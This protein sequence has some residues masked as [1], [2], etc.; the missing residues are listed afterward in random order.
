M[1]FAKMLMAFTARLS[2]AGLLIANMLVTGAQ[3][4]DRIVI[5]QYGTVLATLP[6]AVALNRGFLNKHALDIDGFIGSNGGGTSIRNMI[7]SHIPFAE[8]AP[9]AAIAGVRSGLK[10]KI[11]FTATN[12]T[13]DLNWMVLKD[14]PIK[15][16]A[17]LK[18]R[19]IGFD[20]PQGA[21]EMEIRLVLQR[22]KM[23]GAAELIT[24]G[25]SAVGVTALESGAID[26]APYPNAN[27]PP[28][29]RILF[30]VIQYIPQLT[31]EVGV[32]TEDYAKERP[33][34]LRALVAARREAVD[35][36]YSHPA[37]A[38]QIYANVW[39]VDESVAR[40]IVNS[41]IQ[42]NYW[43]RGNF[44]QDGLT[45]MAQGMNLVN[46]ANATVDINT[47]IDRRFLPA[48]L[49]K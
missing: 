42:K 37:E 1:V 7:A 33:D 29:E 20:S 35:Y 38:A 18:G 24:T 9:A 3:A 28:K 8:V 6:W 30:K 36:I 25:G 16:L 13:A 23:D 40:P 15:T 19:K 46:P 41:A 10:L 47:L 44:I 22:N 43:S 32:T 39:A 21:T 11:I 26:A 4:S 12:N 34:T 5:T 14:S 49:R 45:S 17:D 48:D 31:A 2:L 27:I